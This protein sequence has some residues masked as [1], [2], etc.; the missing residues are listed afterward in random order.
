MRLHVTPAPHGST[1]LASEDKT[2]DGPPKGSRRLRMRDDVWAQTQHQSFFVG[3]RAGVPAVIVGLG[4]RRCSS[5][6]AEEDRRTACRSVG[7][8]SPD[9]GGRGYFPKL[10]VIRKATADFTGGTIHFSPGLG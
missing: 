9:G 7:E 1:R 6:V 4:K 5:G 8:A 3:F 2:T 10:R